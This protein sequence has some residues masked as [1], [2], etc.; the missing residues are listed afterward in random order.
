MMAANPRKRN[1]NRTF[2]VFCFIACLLGLARDSPAR[3]VSRL[4][5]TSY[6]PSLFVPNLPTH[7]DWYSSGMRSYVSRHSGW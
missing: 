1:V 6:A 5:Y 2:Q 4:C 3:Q 7:A